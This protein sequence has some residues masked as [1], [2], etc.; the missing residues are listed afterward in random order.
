MRGM[1]LQ[2]VAIVILICGCRGLLQR[3]LPQPAPLPVAH[4][5]RVEQLVLHS[6]FEL[7]RD[8]RLVRELTAERD[9]LSRPL[10]LPSSDELIEVYLFRDAEAYGRYLARH[11][12]SVPSRRAFF[13]ETDA[14]LAVYAH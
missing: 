11:F 7:P 4:H 12:P 3:G 1:G 5:L 10:G 14:R 8:H 13:V 9:D 2:S 6:D